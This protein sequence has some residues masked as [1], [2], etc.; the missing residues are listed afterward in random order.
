MRRVSYRPSS[1]FDSGPGGGI[2]GGR[3]KELAIRPM[4]DLRNGIR[5]I[6]QAC[7]NDPSRMMDIVQAVQVRYGWVGD[8]AIDLIAAAVSTPRVRVASVVH[9]EDSWFA[10]AGRRTLVERGYHCSHTYPTCSGYGAIAVQE[11]NVGSS[12]CGRF[13]WQSALHD[14]A[15]TGRISHVCAARPTC[16][17]DD[18]TP[19]LSVSSGFLT[20]SLATRRSGVRASC[21]PLNNSLQIRHLRSW[22]DDGRRA[23]RF[24]GCN[25]SAARPTR[26]AT[27]TRPHGGATRRGSRTTRRN[28]RASSTRR[29]W[30][31]A[32]T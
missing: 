18:L 3:R 14:H 15:Q 32:A 23:F 29:E 12:H 11:G 13:L 9:D 19:Y 28:S 5:D 6:C 1:V 7:G 17:Y 27:D 20:A 4:S 22:P 21:R 2:I 30:P 26:A 10:G 16:R 31:N 8:E 24:R 25:R